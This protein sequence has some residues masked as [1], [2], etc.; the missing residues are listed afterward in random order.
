MVEGLQSLNL[1]TKSLLRRPYSLLSFY[2]LKELVLSN[3]LQSNLL[4]LL[5]PLLV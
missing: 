2:L 3:I 5:N 4:Y 1:Y